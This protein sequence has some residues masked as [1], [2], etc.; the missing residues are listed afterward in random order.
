MATAQRTAVGASGPR[1]IVGPALAELLS[2]GATH[3]QHRGQRS[4]L[5]AGWPDFPKPSSRAANSPAQGVP[6]HRRRRPPPIPPPPADPP[7][8]SRSPPPSGCSVLW[9][10]VAAASSRPQASPAVAPTRPATPAACGSLC[11]PR[12]GPRPGSWA[13]LWAGALGALRAAAGGELPGRGRGSGS[14]SRGILARRART[15]R[16]LRHGA[17]GAGALRHADAGRGPKQAPR[18]EPGTPR[19]RGKEALEASGERACARPAACRGLPRGAEPAPTAQRELLRSCL[20]RCTS[21]PGPTR[22]RATKAPSELTLPTRRE[23]RELLVERK[24]GRPVEAARG[25]APPGPEHS[26][27]SRAGAAAVASA[28]SGPRAPLPGAE[29]GVGTP[30]KEPSKSP[31]AAGRLEADCPRAQRG[32]RP[33]PARWRRPGSDCPPPAAAA[34][35]AAAAASARIRARLG[36]RAIITGARGDVTR[37]PAPPPPPRGVLEN[38]GGTRAAHTRTHALRA[39]CLPRTLAAS[40]PARSSAHT[41]AALERPRPSLAPQGHAPSERTLTPTSHASA[42]RKL[43]SPADAPPPSACATGSSPQ[44]SPRHTLCTVTLPAPPAPRG[45]K[46]TCRGPLG[47]YL[48]DGGSHPH[49]RALFS[50]CPD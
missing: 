22:E 42:P 12:P 31:D 29:E 14:G 13:A 48:E 41:D 30:Q 9:T 5:P 20:P 46:G 25:T 44:L 33:A 34:A 10:H 21:L 7:F 26:Y 50:L 1:D 15:L 27:P 45:R 6:H 2:R 36:H 40:R 3:R 43:V 17:R 37:T 47:G 35:A 23:P 4:D 28:S 19:N 18:A 8:V 39:R 49:R 32:G 38:C 11:V 24:P 16:R